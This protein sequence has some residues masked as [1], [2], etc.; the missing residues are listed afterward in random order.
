LTAELFESTL[1]SALGEFDE[2]E[3]HVATAVSVVRDFAVPRM[4]GACL[5]AFAKVA[6]DRGD[7]AR[8]SRLLATAESSVR[9][10][11][12]PF[13]APPEILVAD[14]CIGVLRGVL[15][16]ETARITQ[17]E[18]RALSVKQALDGELIRSGA[19]AEAT[20]AG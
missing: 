14:H 4:E 17:A 5:I 11:D 7:Y 10:E 6:L 20:P 16:A 8:A 19:T 12:K 9:P 18:G 2:A 13:Q 15:D 1:A 3:Q